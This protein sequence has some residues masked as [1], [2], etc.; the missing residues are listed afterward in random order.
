[1][2]KDDLAS[3]FTDPNEASSEINS[4][5]I[6]ECGQVNSVS[7][8]KIC[9][10]GKPKPYWTTLDHKVL[11]LSQM[12]MGHLN[13]SVRMLAEKMEQFPA[14]QRTKYE[15]ALDMLY[16]EIGN[17]PKEIEQM[18]GIMAALQRGIEREKEG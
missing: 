14:E 9:K 2:S 4:H 1:M 3:L 6:C 5:A 7:I 16:E 13:N 8:P 11:K 10:C 17:R 15:V 18:T 12:T